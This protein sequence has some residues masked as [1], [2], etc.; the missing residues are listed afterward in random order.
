MSPLRVGWS[1]DGAIGGFWPG[2]LHGHPT[3]RLSPPEDT[4]VRDHAHFHAEDS[5]IQL[6]A[7]TYRNPAPL[8]QRLN[9]K[10]SPKPEEN[11]VSR[12]EPGEA[13]S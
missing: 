2:H 5:F 8:R 7:G 13:T 9:F 4:D 11:R 12:H 10:L 3:A 1:M 6:D